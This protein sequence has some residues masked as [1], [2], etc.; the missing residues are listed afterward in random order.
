MSCVL[1]APAAGAVRTLRLLGR[2]G[3]GLHSPPGLRARAP[4]A[5][6][7]G[8]G[9]DEPGRPIQFSCSGASPARWTVAQSLGRQQQR[10]W[11]KV[12]P[13]SLSLMLLV[14]WCF[15]RP[16]SGADVW[17][18]RVLDGEEPGRGGRA[19]APGARA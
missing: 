4:S 16:E 3:R 18:Q 15:L 13:L 6:E 7:G 19:E 10:P 8:E 17:L 1:G 9:E 5:A 2:A 14:A 11:W 12:L